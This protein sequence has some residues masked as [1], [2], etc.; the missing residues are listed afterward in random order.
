MTT[1]LPTTTSDDH[2]W[3][4]PTLPPR[5]PKP[6]E[7]QYFLCHASRSGYA[8]SLPETRNCLPPTANN[9]CLLRLQV[10]VWSETKK[11]TIIDAVKCYKRIRTVCTHEGFF[12][13][14]GGRGVTKDITTIEPVNQARC[15]IAR[16]LHQY[17]DDDGKTKPL[18]QM[19]PDLWTSN[20]TLEVSYSWCCTDN[21]VTTTNF[22]MET[23]TVLT[24]DGQLVSSDLGELGGCHAY[25]AYCIRPDSVIIWNAT[26]LRHNAYCAYERKGPF[27]AVLSIQRHVLI[28]SLQG[29]FKIV[30]SDFA[31]RPH[32]IPRDVYKLNAGHLWIQLHKV[33]NITIAP[34]T[35]ARILGCK[36]LSEQVHTHKHVSHFKPKAVTIKPDLSP[37]KRM[38]RE[39]NDTISDMVNAK[40]NYLTEIIRNYELENFKNIW[41]ELCEKANYDVRLTRQLTRIDATLGMRVALKREDIHASFAGSA[42][43]IF[44]CR[45]VFIHPRDIY[46]DAKINETCYE[47]LPVRYQGRLYFV[48][49]GSR[50]LVQDSPTVDCAHRIPFYFKHDN[51]WTSAHGRVPVHELQA[52]ADWK[53]EFSLL[54]FNSSFLQHD[55]LAGITVTAISQLRHYIMKLKTHAIQLEGLID[56]T[57]AQSLNPRA[58]T[59]TLKGVG[60]MVGEALVGGGKAIE[61][62][63]LG[64][65]KG[66]ATFVNKL[67]SGPILLFTVVAVILLIVLLCAF[68][69]YK[70]WKNQKHRGQQRR[71]SVVPPA[72]RQRRLATVAERLRRRSSMRFASFHHYLTTLR[73][74]SGYYSPAAHTNEY[75]LAELPDTSTFRPQRDSIASYHFRPFSA[76]Y[77][78]DE[79]TFYEDPD[80][81]TASRPP[82]CCC[83]TNT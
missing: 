51:V 37:S 60:Q 59:A 20:H 10:D 29:A 72:R 47:Y 6:A 26:A 1:T 55:F 76:Q 28:D 77:Y 15:Q 64:G 73:R 48:S 2:F 23:G 27:W 56:Y 52:E 63:I 32:C 82:H 79:T 21:C 71:T 66:T 83:S 42:V 31:E 57:A 22:V 24:T 3:R 46:W 19:G 65:A 8:V 45:S 9:P 18:V 7:D 74:R 69:C 54:W 50:D 81:P 43:M 80:Q 49:P 30:K 75:E 25:Q 53:P 12:G 34:G 11:P 14:F 16:L 39:S 13:T 35:W 61:H 44:P 58:L 67:I 38:K 4:D 41:V 62:V 68:A 70:I 17:V 33:G 36:P 5:P 78:A 40:L